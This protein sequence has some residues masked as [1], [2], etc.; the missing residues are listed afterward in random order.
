MGKR[1]AAITCAWI[2]AAAIV[3]LSLAPEVPDPG[4]EHGDK[5]A[6]FLAYAA[7]MF[8][9]CYLYRDTR[10]RIGYAL[11]WIAMG[12]ALEFAQGST[13]YRSLELADM[14]ANALGVLAGAAAALTLTRA[15]GAAKRETP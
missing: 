15:A 1:V 12:V 2:Y 10:V 7:L 8:W 9:F 3:W 13:G 4:V 6:H 11:L 5:L 14:A